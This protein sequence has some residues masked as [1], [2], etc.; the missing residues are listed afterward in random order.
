MK[1]ATST[2]LLAFLAVCRLCGAF[3]P[4]PART[5]TTIVAVRHRAL[6]SSPSARSQQGRHRTSVRMQQQPGSDEE[7]QVAVSRLAAQVEDLTAMVAQLAAEP[8]GGA[9]GAKG[10][11]GA[12]VD[13]G[14][15]VPVVSTKAKGE[16]KPPLVRCVKMGRVRNID[17]CTA[18]SCVFP[19]LNSGPLAPL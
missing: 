6:S 13:T 2:L 1:R 18:C 15:G 7:L 12:V 10:I 14:A 5:T 8:A 17:I 16:S 9:G 4:A 11:N 3:L 19:L